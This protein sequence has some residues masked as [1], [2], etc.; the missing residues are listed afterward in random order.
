[1]QF[2]NGKVCW[3]AAV[4]LALVMPAAAVAADSLAAA[5]ADQ[6]AGK[7]DEA[8]VALGAALKANAN[9]AEALNLLCRVEY[10]TEHFDQAAS[11]CQKAVSLD[12]QNARYHLWLGRAI[13][14]RASR[15]SFLSAYSLAKKTRAE[16]EQAVKLDPR[17]ADALADLGEF[18]KE[19]PGAV[20]GGTDKANAIAQKLD[21]VDASRAHQLRALIAEKN[22]D[23]GTAEREFKAACAGPRAAIQWMELANFYRRHK[24][25]SEMEGAIK[26]GEAAAHGKDGALALFEGAGVLARTGHGSEAIKLYEQYLASSNKSEEA[27]AFDALTR[28]AKLRMK[29]GDEAGA[30]RDQA[31]ALALAHDYKPA[32][33]ALEDKH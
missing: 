28:I 3:S 22:D 18:Y 19:A 13:G 33:E 11:D 15:A 6:D 16:F 21:G 4:C 12:P 24:R 14:E 9:N 17:D 1:M 7:A 10:A 23:L 27:P 20:G 30:K 2:L 31:A 32:Q 25:D 8:A 29:A 5:R 26:S